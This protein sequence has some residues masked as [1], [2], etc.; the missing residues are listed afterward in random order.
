M[1]GPPRM[2]MSAWPAG[3]GGVPHAA[4][5]AAATQAVSATDQYPRLDIAVSPSSPSAL[6]AAFKLTRAWSPLDAGGGRSHRP[7]VQA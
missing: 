5:A 3:V 6:E 7:G 4:V 1:T 2:T